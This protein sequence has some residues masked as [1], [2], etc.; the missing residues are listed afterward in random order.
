MARLFRILRGADERLTGSFDHAFNAALNP[1]RHLGALAFLCLSIA[2]TSGVVAYALY[3]TSVNG[4]Y[5]SG[6]RLQQAPLML[7]RVLRGLHRYAADACLALTVLHLLREAVRGHFGRVRWFAWVSGIPLLWLVWIAG[8]T[9]L[10]LPWDAL[11]L[12][13]AAATAE[14]LQALPVSADLLVRNFLTPEALN[15]RFFSLVVFVHIGVPLLL[16]AGVWIHVQRVSHVRVWPPRAL[17]LGSLTMLVLLALVAP[18]ESLGQADPLRRPATLALDWFYLFLHPLVDALSAPAVWWLAATLTAGLATLPLWPKEQT[19]GAIHAP[20]RVDLAHCNGC[21]RCAADCPFGA[22]IM[23][24]RSDGRHHLQQAQVNADLCVACGICAGACPSSTPFRR[25]EKFVSGIDLPDLPVDLL[26]SQMH[27]RTAELTGTSKLM[28]FTCRQAAHGAA[29]ADAGTAGMTLECTAMLAPSFIEYALRLGV[30]GVVIAGCHEGDCEYRLG[31]R[32]TSERLAG[33]REPRLRAAAPR[34][35]V[36]VVWSGGD[37]R[38]VRQAIATLRHRLT[39]MD[40]VPGPDE[41][42]PIA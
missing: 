14:W 34:N 36:E 5:A 41:Q 22:V 13:S 29:F 20:A 23:V 19:P 32:W 9:G 1:W 3:D 27:Q 8:L 7:G 42:A 25:V 33:T 37:A 26:R 21:A 40:D 16:L 30:S 12:Y 38:Q 31:D 11:A 4:A 15:D 35:R 18:V 17:I 39:S 28:L 6:L 10:W 2:V 24:P